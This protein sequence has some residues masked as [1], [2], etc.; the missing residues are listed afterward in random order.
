MC[1]MQ[2]SLHLLGQLT[3]FI[4]PSCLNR[5]RTGMFIL[6]VNLSVMAS[7]LSLVLLVFF[8]CQPTVGARMKLLE[9]TAASDAGICKLMVEMWGYVCQEHTVI[10]V[11][12]LLD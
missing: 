10:F 11:P 12:F 5:T 8:F 2:D 9:L 1:H 4:F 7:T 6:V 3:P